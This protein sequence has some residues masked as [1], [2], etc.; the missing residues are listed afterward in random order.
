MKNPSRSKNSAHRASD[1]CSY[2]EGFFVFFIWIII[3]TVR[4]LHI[5]K[6]CLHAKAVYENIE[7]ADVSPHE[8]GICKSVQYSDEDRHFCISF[9]KRAYC[10][11][12]K[13][14]HGEAEIVYNGAENA[15]WCATF[16]I[17]DGKV[18]C[19]NG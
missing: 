6:Y 5:Y 18:L 1:S 11:C 7:H 3:Q 10:S 4:E 16:N 17:E 8:E 12:S 9:F 19:Q 14:F 2:A 13:D 15:R